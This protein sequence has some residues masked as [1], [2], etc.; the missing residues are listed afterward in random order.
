MDNKSFVNNQILIAEK[1]KKLTLIKSLLTPRRLFAK[2]RFLS[3]PSQSS[4]MAYEG[5]SDD[6]EL[7]AE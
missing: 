3:S 7:A 2:D 5:G 4:S 1:Y 6:E